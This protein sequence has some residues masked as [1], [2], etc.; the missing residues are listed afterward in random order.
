M[1]R[2]SEEKQEKTAARRCYDAGY[3]AAQF[4]SSLP[5]SQSIE[6]RGSACFVHLSERWRQ[7][8]LDVLWVGFSEP[9]GIV[10]ILDNSG[11]MPVHFAPTEL[12]EELCFPFFWA[13]LMRRATT[14]V[15]PELLY[16]VLLAKLHVE[17]CLD[18]HM[19]SE[20]IQ[21]GKWSPLAVRAMLDGAP[22]PG[23]LFQPREYQLLCRR[24]RK[25]AECL[26]ALRAV[27]PQKDFRCRWIDIGYEGVVSERLSAADLVVG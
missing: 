7:A 8:A 9:I 19:E 1:K 2:R 14:T 16:N 26:S 20:I 10:S 4:D 5:L 22:M 13:C 18:M 15:E 12:G 17:G 11:L 24:L 27:P 3:R 25:L 23:V 6:D 21:S